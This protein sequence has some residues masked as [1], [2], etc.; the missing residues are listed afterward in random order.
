MAAAPLNDSLLKSGDEEKNPS[1]YPEALGRGRASIAAAVLTVGTVAFVAGRW[2]S[3][4]PEAEAVDRDAV[5]GKLAS[6]RG[7]NQTTSLMVVPYTSTCYGFT[8]GSCATRDCDASRNAVCAE[9]KC[10]CKSGCTGVDGVCRDETYTK[11]GSD[12]TLV[13]VK[14]NWQGLYM[15]RF[16]VLGQ[17]MTSAAPDSLFFGS[18][19]FDLFELPGRIKGHKE[20]LLT[21]KIWPNWVASIRTTGSV[22]SGSASLWGLYALNLYHTIAPW[23]PQSLVVRICSMEKHGYK[24]AIMIGSPGATGRSIKA[25]LHHGSWFVYGWDLSADPGE[26]GYWTVDKNLEGIED[27]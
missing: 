23:D 11:V 18:N 22:L 17:L 27:C 13:N 6:V 7:A 15:Q 14:Y 9:A 24:N 25:Y 21:S 19:K 5:L 4:V 20:Y 12:F 8:G 10:V 2:A 3:N 26:G 1:R 16:G